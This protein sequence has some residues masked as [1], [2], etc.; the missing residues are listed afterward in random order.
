MGQKFLTLAFYFLLGFLGTTLVVCF[1]D[2]FW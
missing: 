1:L 2:I